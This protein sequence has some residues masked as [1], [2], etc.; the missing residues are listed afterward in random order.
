MGGVVARGPGHVTARMGPGSAEIVVCDWGAIAVP[1]SEGPGGE[2]LLRGH[3]QVQ[4]VAVG[5]PDLAYQVQG[6]NDL[7]IDDGA[8]DVGC[9][10][11]KGVDNDVGHLFPC[12]V[13]RAIG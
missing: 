5:E 8:L 10:N 4:N 11:G 1:A 13:P 7:P 9:V 12:I 6:R 2:E 3:I